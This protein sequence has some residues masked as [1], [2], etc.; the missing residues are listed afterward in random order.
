MDEALDLHADISVWPL[1]VNEVS[2]VVAK[3]SISAT[4]MSY[5]SAEE[6]A[7]KLAAHLRELV[8]ETDETE[9]LDF[10]RHLVFDPLV[11]ILGSPIQDLVPLAGTGAAGVSAAV[12]TG[13]PQAGMFVLFAGVGY[14]VVYNVFVPAA[15]EIGE[16]LRLWLRKLRPAD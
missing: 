13:D 1:D 12:Y 7:R 2:D 16:V 9:V 10:T 4:A 15:K 11:P 8:P 14:T 5:E 6:L 3:L